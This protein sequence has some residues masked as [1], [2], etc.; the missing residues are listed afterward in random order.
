M[1]LATFLEVELAMIPST[2]SYPEIVPIGT[3]SLVKMVMIPS[4][5][6]TLICM[7]ATGMTL[8]VAGSGINYCAKVCLRCAY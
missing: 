3:L 4:T 8:Y 5:V 7:A 1:M 6:F 2:A